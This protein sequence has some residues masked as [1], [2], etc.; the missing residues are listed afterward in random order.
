MPGELGAQP[1]AHTIG[2]LNVARLAASLHAVEPRDPEVEIHVAPAKRDRL[3]NPAARVGE[4]KDESEVI[5]S[6]ALRYFEEVHAL[7]CIE[8][9]ERGARPELKASG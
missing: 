8:H 4:E 1:L 9:L 3:A 5:R 2:Q 7:G 6:R